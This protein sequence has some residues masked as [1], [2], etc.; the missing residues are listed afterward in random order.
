MQRGAQFRGETLFIVTKVSDFLFLVFLFLR[1]YEEERNEN[2][3]LALTSYPPP[4]PP[5]QSLILRLSVSFQP[6]E[7]FKLGSLK[8]QI[9]NSRSLYK[10]LD[11]F[12]AL[13]FTL[14][15]FDVHIQTY[16]QLM[17]GVALV[18][19]VTYYID[20]KALNINHLKKLS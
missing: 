11:S 18:F 19:H 9:Q 12:V 5:K 17:V 15:N 7:K 10:Y 13:T 4:H 8:T 2:P 3:L 1:N 14:K 16:L 6:S 20:F